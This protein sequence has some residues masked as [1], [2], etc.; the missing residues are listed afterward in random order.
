MMFSS[1][2]A[3]NQKAKPRRSEGG[4]VT[5]KHTITGKELLIIMDRELQMPTC[6]WR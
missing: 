3:A 5:K 6:K 2:T 1:N 4:R